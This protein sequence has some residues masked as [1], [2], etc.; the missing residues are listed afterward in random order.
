MAIN[1]NHLSYKDFVKLECRTLN[2]LS[3][4]SFI[5]NTYSSLSTSATTSYAKYGHLKDTEIN[6]NDFVFEC[7]FEIMV[8]KEP[9]TILIESLVRKNFEV[10]SY[11]LSICS[12]N[13]CLRKFHFD[14]ALKIPNDTYP[15]PIY[16]LQ[17]G[18][19]PSPGIERM[20]I[21]INEL[22]PWL[23]SPRISFVPMNLALLFD[24]VFCEF[25][26]ED[27]R[28]ITERP[29][30][31]ELIKSNEEKILLPFYNRMKDFLKN[32]KSSYPNLIRDFYYG[33]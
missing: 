3:T 2:F 5:Y 26:V 11:V 12:D 24:M 8:E 22:H 32:H 7:S 18:G 6:K 20:Q 29:E 28:K 19:K 4:N 33:N 1:K 21:D 25:R 27:T 17:Y 9:R 10:V 31:R 15:K 23:S 16:H 14:Y 13:R 30:W